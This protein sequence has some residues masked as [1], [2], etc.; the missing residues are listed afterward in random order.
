VLGQRSATQLPDRA[1]RRTR[2]GRVEFAV[3][4]RWRQPFA[5][6]EM[7]HRRMSAQR[8]ED[9][10]PEMALRKALHALGLRY[11]LHRA[12]LSTL[13][14]RADIVFGPAHVA[15]FVDGCFWHGC[16]EHGQR[17][18][19]VNGWYWPE[20]IARNQERDRDTDRALADA[21]WQVLR[22]WE[23]E[24]VGNGAVVAARRVQETISQRRLR[25]GPALKL[26]ATSA[27]TQPVQTKCGNGD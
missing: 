22:V 21:G 3:P 9:T 12:P 5:S 26:S 27:T 11:R 25:S 19:N 23:H 8:R 13:R 17:R 20:K 24:V 14:R 2:A 18:H 15:V 1:S 6:T 7:I 16:P 10:A 4:E